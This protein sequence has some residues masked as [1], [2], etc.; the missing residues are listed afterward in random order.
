[1]ETNF[2]RDAWFLPGN[3]HGCADQVYRIYA[4]YDS[5]EPSWEIQPIWADQ[6]LKAYQEA[7]HAPAEKRYFWFEDALCEYC[8][9]QWK[10]TDMES[11]YGKELAEAYPTAD[12]YGFPE[13]PFELIEWAK[14]RTENETDFDLR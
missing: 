3:I 2:E 13:I 12:F 8:Q 9:G 11:E 6:I 4:N 7:S 14:S 5:T 1:M 10:W